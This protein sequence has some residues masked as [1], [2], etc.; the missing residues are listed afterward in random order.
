MDLRIAPLADSSSSN[1]KSK[2]FLFNTDRPTAADI[3]L[4]ALSFPILL[5][6][7]CSSLFATAKFMSEQDV[8]LAAGCR[9]MADVAKQ[10]LEEHRSA[11]YALY[12]Y[13]T[14]RFFSSQHPLLSGS[15]SITSTATHTSTSHSSDRVVIPK[16]R[17]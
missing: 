10:L 14:Y 6:L 4:A 8:V 9:R 1:I 15:S 16:P 3:T 5:P 13:D 11:R 7:Q 12:L 17:K 2:T